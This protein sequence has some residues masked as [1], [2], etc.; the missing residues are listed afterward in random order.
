VFLSF[1]FNRQGLVVLEKAMVALADKTKAPTE[2][3]VLIDVAAESQKPVAAGG[4]ASSST[5]KGGLYQPQK[6]TVAQTRKAG[7]Y[8]N[9]CTQQS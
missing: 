8:L 5:P 6:L 9:T 3:L 2:K 7:G 4:A 1:A